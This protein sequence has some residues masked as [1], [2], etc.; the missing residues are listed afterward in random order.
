VI[1]VVIDT[2][3]FVSALI[4]DGTPLAAIETARLGKARLLVTTEIVTEMQRTLERPKFKP[5]FLRRETESHL[6]LN[7]YTTLARYVTPVPVT[8]CP[9]QDKK[10]LMFI[11]CAVGGDADYIV[12]GDHHLLDLKNYQKIM[13]VTPMEFLRLVNSSTDPATDPSS[14]E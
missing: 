5:Y 2:N 9:I 1:T 14:D 7:D 8:D 10:D 6:L 11:E 4:G 3:V 12:S 13:I